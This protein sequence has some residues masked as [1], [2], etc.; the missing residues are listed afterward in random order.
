MESLSLNHLSSEQHLI[1]VKSMHSIVPPPLSHCRSPTLIDFLFKWDFIIVL[2]I[3]L[4]RLGMDMARLRAYFN[5]ICLEKQWHE[6]KHDASCIPYYTIPP[7]HCHLHVRFYNKSKPI[8]MKWK[9][10]IDQFPKKSREFSELLC[11]DSQILFFFAP[12]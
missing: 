12:I 11:K 4:L 5:C 8:E 2:D 7:Y 1:I 10:N 6:M 9:E 3:N